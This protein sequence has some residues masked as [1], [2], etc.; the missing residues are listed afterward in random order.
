M[1]IHSILKILGFTFPSSDGTNGQALKTDGA[2]VLSFGDA[3]LTKFTEAESTTGENATVYVQ[4]LTV[5][6]GSTNSDSAIVPK[7]TGAFLSSVPDGTAT[8]GNKRGANAVDLQTK[9]SSASE[10]ASG[11]Y[12]GIPYGKDN[13]A[14]STSAGA[15]GDGCTASN[16]YAQAGGLDCTASGISSGAFGET[17]TVTSSNG[18]GI[19]RLITVSG[20]QGFGAGFGGKV[21]SERGCG[22]GS[23]YHTFGVYGRF[24]YSSGRISADGDSQV[25]T[26]PLKARTTDATAT[27]LTTDNSTASTDNQLIL[28]DN[29]VITFTGT[30][31]GKKTATTDVAS[32]KIEGLIKRGSGV[33]SVVLVTST[34]T[35]IDN[36]PAWGTPTLTAD[37]TNGGLKVDVTGLA[38]TNIQWGCR[39]DTNEVIY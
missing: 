4:S 35:V 20:N 2:G 30:I 25:S 16:T 22:L 37:V 31:V 23:Y 3:G 15:W 12:A 33:G 28:Q 11:T 5:V 39:I 32:W 24:V 6:S 1:K 18:F 17:V 36:T 21:D 19:G 10:V 27:V 7:G 34:V 26:L 29:Q 14:T 13:K 9:R 8:G 38:S